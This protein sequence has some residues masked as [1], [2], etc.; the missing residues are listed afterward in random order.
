M[1]GSRGTVLVVDDEVL[2][3]FLMAEELRNAGYN[4]IE[5]SSADEALV[6]LCAQV[7]AD[8]MISDVRMPGIMDG[9]GL[10]RAARVI[11]PELA[12]ALSSAHFNPAAD[13]LAGV[14]DDFLPKPYLSNRLIELADRLLEAP[15]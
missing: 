8:L 15:R 7:P 13:E 14:V 11:R 10:A 12:I 4:V 3:R 1:T 5:A 9:V 6:L 2:I